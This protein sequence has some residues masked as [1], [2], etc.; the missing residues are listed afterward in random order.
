MKWYIYLQIPL[1]KQDVTQGQFFKGS[2]TGLNS[3]FSFSL[4]SCH[5]K[6]GKPCLP[7][8]LPVAEGYMK[9][10]QPLPGFE[11][12]SLHP[13]HKCLQIIYIYTYIYIYIYIIFIFRER[14]NSRELCRT[15]T[16]LKWQWQVLHFKIH[17]FC[18][19]TPLSQVPVNC[20]YF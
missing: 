8:Y 12:C 16:L 3:E 2:F 14:E 7:Y 5:T 10:K 9:W 19:L 11:L 15:D 1:N 4:N 6:I 13:L 18:H 17:V 20:N